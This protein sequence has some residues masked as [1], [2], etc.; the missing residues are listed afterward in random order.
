LAGCVG[1]VKD[2]APHLVAHDVTQ[3]PML[4][5]QPSTYPTQR[6]SQSRFTTRRS[7]Q[8]VRLPYTTRGRLP[9]SGPASR[10]TCRPSHTRWRR[11][12]A[13]GRLLAGSWS[14]SYPIYDT[15]SEAH[16]AVSA[17]RTERFR[18]SASR[19]RQLSRRSAGQHSSGPLLDERPLDDGE[20]DLEALHGLTLRA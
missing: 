1:A 11:R 20:L 15:A 17:A 5:P 18:Q 2:P 12:V 4:I 19:A 3:R 7:R 9:L 13:E 10:A 14:K 8:P 16:R 6:A